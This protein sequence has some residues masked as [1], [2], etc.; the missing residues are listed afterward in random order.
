MAQD[1]V[2]RPTA[3]AG[4]VAPALKI[5]TGDRTWVLTSIALVLA[6][7]RLGLRPSTADWSGAS[8][9]GHDHAER[10]HALP[11]QPDR[12]SCLV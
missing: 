11:G 9:P 12:D 2:P 4:A 3:G 6:M 7:T 8:Y 5:D 1:P 10:R